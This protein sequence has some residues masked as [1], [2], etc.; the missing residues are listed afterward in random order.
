MVLCLL[1]LLAVAA[2]QKTIALLAREGD[3]LSME[4]RTALLR[5]SP[6]WGRYFD[7]ATEKALAIEPS[8]PEDSPENLKH[9]IATARREAQSAPTAIARALL[10][11][12]TMALIRLLPPSALSFRS[13]A[14]I[15]LFREYGRLLLQLDPKDPRIDA[16]MEEL[17]FR[18]SFQP[19][20]HV[21][22]SVFVARYDQVRARL[23]KQRPQQL[24]LEI[25]PAGRAST[26][27][28]G[29]EPEPYEGQQLSLLPGVHELVIKSD[30]PG[31]TRR[32][33]I[34]SNAGVVRL[35]IDLEAEARV[36]FTP[37][38]FA[39]RASSGELGKDVGAFVAEQARASELWLIE[40]AAHGH[41]KVTIYDA[42]RTTLRSALVEL[43]GRPVEAR[44]LH[45]ALRS[46]RETVSEQPLQVRV[47]P[48]TAG[49]PM[50][51]GLPVQ[52][53]ASPV[54]KR[55]WF[56]VI[57]GG[58]AAAAAATTTAVVVLTAPRSTEPLPANVHVSFE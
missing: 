5:A 38:G 44:L 25:R 49:G 56:W 23:A 18:D 45:A 19:Q 35:R 30:R 22:D 36:T 15:A 27:I 2:P 11:E 57:M 16:L 4:A 37:S 58:V 42:E 39:L 41:A 55:W 21:N 8:W 50:R 46:V 14:L 26:S 3:A 28:D 53:S 29:R 1:S 40:G 48:T 47:V 33:N 9:L 17:A 7:P 20:T 24:V 10:Y 6:P 12:K 13:Q 31:F 52:A 54:Y 34:A 51:D 32:L 43:Q